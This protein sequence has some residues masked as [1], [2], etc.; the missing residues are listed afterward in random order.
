MLE[1]KV[2]V[3]RATMREDEAAKTAERAEA[4]IAIADP[5]HRAASVSSGS[6]PGEKFTYE[7][8][9]PFYKYQKRLILGNNGRIDPTNIEDYIG[10]GGYGAL[11][12]AMQ[13]GK[14]D[15]IGTPAGVPVGRAA[16]E[17]RTP[18]AR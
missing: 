9:V 18:G 5:E 4:M 7:E 1:G 3:L 17:P 12:N 13:D 10:I 15:L 2:A 16:R 11:A 6:V 8:D 14:A